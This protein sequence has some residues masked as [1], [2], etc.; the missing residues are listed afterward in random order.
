[1]VYDGRW[2]KFCCSRCCGI[3]EPGELLWRRTHE[4]LTKRLRRIPHMKALLRHNSA[5]VYRFLLLNWP[6]V[7]TAEELIPPERAPQS[8]KPFAKIGIH[9]PRCLWRAYSP[10][11]LMT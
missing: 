9:W 11:V 4:R 1:M 6:Q 2:A 3:N 10:Q 8:V 5:T 7:K